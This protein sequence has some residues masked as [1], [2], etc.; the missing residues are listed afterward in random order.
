[1]KYLDSLNLPPMERLKYEAA[2]IDDPALFERQMMEGTAFSDISED[3]RLREA[4][5]ASLQGLQDRAGEGYT[6]EDRAAIDA[7]MGD[8]LA[9]S[10]GAQEAMQQ[11]Y[12][13][14]G[15]AGSGLEAGQRAIAQQSAIGNA[16]RQG[17]QQ[18]VG[19]RQAA[20]QAM[21][22]A[23]QLGGQI[24]GQEF[25]QKAQIAGEEDSL[26]RFNINQ[27]NQGQQARFQ[28]DLANQQAINLAAQQGANAEMQRAKME[29]DIAA[30]KAQLRAS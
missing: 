2:L 6:I 17:M 14:R 5:M 29:A 25:G 3:P 12:A 20:L 30:S 13:R 11:Q 23:G 15:M 22:G 10:R 9:Q 18:A 4:Q 19:S 21:Q 27:A 16:A 7:L 8:I 28:A 26:S 1:M 24:R